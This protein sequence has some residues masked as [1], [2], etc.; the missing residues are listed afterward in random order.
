MGSAPVTW[1]CARKPRSLLVFGKD[2]GHPQ[3]YR[4][5]LRM[6]SSVDISDLHH[7]MLSNSS[8]IV[9][10]IST[11]TSSDGLLVLAWEC[12]Q[13]T[14]GD[15]LQRSPMTLP[16]KLTVKGTRPIAWVDHLVLSLSSRVHRGSSILPFP[17]HF[18]LLLKL[19]GSYTLN[20]FKLEL[21]YRRL[22]PLHME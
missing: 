16:C 13:H 6:L 21:P 5:P 4:A 11:S 15:D 17:T 22:N 3:R 1:S 9:C 12:H 19:D 18:S 2:L 8:K 10:A 7:F 14:Q 20:R